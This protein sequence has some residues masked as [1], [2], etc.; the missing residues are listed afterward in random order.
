MRKA[1]SDFEAECNFA[2][3]PPEEIE[4][5]CKYEYMRE[6]R[7]LRAAVRHR[8]NK[9]FRHPH[10]Y[11]I[12]PYLDRL[13][14]LCTADCPRQ[15]GF[16]QSE[17]RIYC[18]HCKNAADLPCEDWVKKLFEA[19]RRKAARSAER[20]LMKKKARINVLPS[21]TR[22]ERYRLVLA[23][24]KAGFPAPWKE[25]N[26]EARNE[27]I[28]PIGDWDRER[29]K[30]FP[31]VMI[32]EGVVKRDSERELASP[33]YKLVPLKPQRRDDGDAR[34]WHPPPAAPGEPELLH[35]GQQ[36]GRAYFYGFIRIDESYNQ[37]EVE[38]A[39]TTWLKGRYGKTKGGGTPHWEAKLNDLVVVRLWKQFPKRDDAIKRVQHVAEFTGVVDN[40]RRVPK[41]S[42]LIGVVVDRVGGAR[43]VL[44]PDAVMQVTPGD[45]IIHLPRHAAVLK[46]RHD[47]V[48]ASAIDRCVA[49]LENGAILRV[50]IDYARIAKSELRG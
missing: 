26:N 27:L 30:S 15:Y 4:T 40:V 22:G 8:L 9:D 12:R 13:C 1:E 32:E 28:G 16:W 5:V 10:L 31:P 45:V 47:S 50:D 3:L 21:F 19:A 49:L 48:E 23:L 20:A 24:L 14:R 44:N 43:R 37:T 11:R 35:H 41:H 42:I 25:L 46:T 18:S 7:A 34:L 38:A 6:S 36:S 17:Y 29:K 2:E 33:I 39:F